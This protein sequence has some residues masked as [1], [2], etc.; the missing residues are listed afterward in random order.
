MPARWAWCRAKRWRA[1]SFTGSARASSIA[2]S[3]PPP[4]AEALKATLGTRD[5]TDIEQFQNAKLIVFWGT[6]AI[7]SNLHLWSRAQE[8]KRNGAKLI[9]IDP[10]RSLT[11]EK[12]HEHIALLP[13]TDGALCARRHARA[14]TR[15]LARPRLHRAL[16]ARLRCAGRAR[17]S[18]SIHSAWRGSAASPPTK[19]SSSRATTGRSVPR[20]S[21]LNYGMQ[22]AAGGGN[23]VRAVACLPALAGHWRD[24]AGGV[25]LSTSGNYRSTRHACTAPTCS[26]AARHARST[27]G[28]SATTCCTPT[29]RSMR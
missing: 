11:A 22:R 13:G 28:R 14:G 5:G 24:P 20:R 12:C 16:H 4:G 9:A 25:L 23:A 27:C 15:R 29:R 17:A 26:P 3:A 1:A 10:Y 2:R 21:V 7:A 18:S 19:S 6:N 8:A